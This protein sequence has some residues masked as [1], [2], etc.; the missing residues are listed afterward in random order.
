MYDRRIPW[1]PSA[2]LVSAAQ[3]GDDVVLSGILSAGIPKLAAF[4]RGMGLRSHDAEDLAGDA[5]EAIVKN[6]AKLREP[7]RFETWF[8]RVARSKF[9]DHLRR[10]RRPGPPPER[11]AVF[12]VASEALEVADDHYEIRVAFLALNGRDRELLWMR[13][14]I[15]LGYKDISGR[16]SLSEGAI[17][18]AVMR[19]RRR[20]EEALSDVKVD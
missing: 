12:D 2:E 20:L 11:D 14:V 5:C 10:K 17:R 16:L 1:P 8:W 7:A 15:G 6:F 9:Y 13:D 4:Y 19:A 3:S 18:I